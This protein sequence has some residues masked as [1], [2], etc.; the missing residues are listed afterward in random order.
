M[1]IVVTGGSGGLGSEIVE[2]FD[3]RREKAIPASRRTGFDLTT[4]RG[5]AE[6]ITGADVI[7]HTATHATKHH[8]VDVAGTERL[9]TMMRARV[10][11]THLI[12]VSIVGCD[13]NPIG[14]YRSKTAAEK[15]LAASGLSVTVVRAT[16]FHTLVDAIAENAT[17][18]PLGFAPHGLRFQPCE[19][20][21]V[22][23][24]IV[25]YAFADRPAGFRRADDLAGPELL[26]LAQAIS[27]RAESAG[28]QAPRLIQLPALGTALAAFAEGA[29]L[30]D[31]SAEIGGPSFTAWTAR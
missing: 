1:K 23:R 20:G 15:L 30:P 8:A 17:I 29:N 10:A 5:M 31:D 9:I 21:W 13:R 14:Y 12:Y 4:G 25:D 24:R 6:V 19:L 16:Q 18:G 2:E 11:T 22:A 28:H 3:H 7:V 27:V 26:S